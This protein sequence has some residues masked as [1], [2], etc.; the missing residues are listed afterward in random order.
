MKS[1]HILF[2]HTT[3]VGHLPVESPAGHVHPQSM[4]A[5]HS[6]TKTLVTEINSL[7][8]FAGLFIALGRN[9]TS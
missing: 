9:S 4:R 8:R 3:A 7:R 2:H 5:L 1:E 6:N